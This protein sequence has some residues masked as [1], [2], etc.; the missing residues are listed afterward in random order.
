MGNQFTKAM[1]RSL[2]PCNLQAPESGPLFGRLFSPERQDTKSVK[3][4]LDLDIAHRLATNQNQ[5]IRKRSLWLMIARSAYSLLDGVA[6]EQTA[7]SILLDY[8]DAHI[9]GFS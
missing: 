7:H 8:F 2:R 9:H 5:Q 6:E 3:V 1:R 4:L